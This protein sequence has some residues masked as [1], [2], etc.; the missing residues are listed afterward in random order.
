MSTL[1]S[2][3]A[4]WAAAGCATLLS[5]CFSNSSGG[6]GGASFDSGTLDG[7]FGDDGGGSDAVTADV[8]IDTTQA[9]SGTTLVDSTTP[10]DSGM[11]AVDSGMPVVDSGSPPI[12]S[13][14]PPVDSG[15]SL[16]SGTPP[17]D[18]SPEAEAGAVVGLVSPAPATTWP[19][20][21]T[22]VGSDLYW[23]DEG[24]PA[25]NAGTFQWCTPSLGNCASPTSFG[26]NAMPQ[27]SQLTSDGTTFF[28]TQGSPSQYS[29]YQVETCPLACSPGGEHGINGVGAWDNLTGIATDAY[30]VYY[31]AGL[32]PVSGSNYGI[33]YIPKGGSSM[34]YSLASNLPL[35][36]NLLVVGTSLYYG[37]AGGGIYECP[38]A[39]DGGVE[40]APCTPTLVQS[41]GSTSGLASD[42]T[43]LYWAEPVAGAI[44]KCPVGGCGASTPTLIASNAGGINGLAL[45]GSQVFYTVGVAADAGT[46]NGVYA[47]AK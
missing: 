29:T 45:L 5:A 32:W 39:T 20:G 36:S 16:D 21:I 30:N 8:T 43:S 42:G 27:G 11:T 37:I 24:T 23:L 15:T 2:S 46:V 10:M 14:S 19:V 33:W 1:V 7:S 26:I 44:Y 6:G 18:A 41:T 31:A 35:T 4:L 13:G 38:I 17:V 28:F 9:D 12:D 47:A 25:M 3:R 22:A 40:P 34:G